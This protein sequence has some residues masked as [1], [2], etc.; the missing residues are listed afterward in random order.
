[1][2]QLNLRIRI[3]MMEVFAFNGNTFRDWQALL[4]GNLAF[5]LY[6]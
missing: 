2:N 3:A 1:M 4:W 6:R 5:R